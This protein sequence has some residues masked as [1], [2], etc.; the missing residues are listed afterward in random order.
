[1]SSIVVP[2]VTPA[3]KRIMIVTVAA[4]VVLQIILGRFL[5]LNQWKVLILHPYQV[6]ESFYVWQLFTYQFFHD[7]SPAHILFNM[8]MI[9][10]VG[11]ELESR[12]GAKFFT[13]YYLMSGAGAALI[14]C[15]GTAIYAALTGNKMVMLIP[16]LGASGSLFGLLLAYGIIFSERTIYFMGFFPLKAKHFV[17]LAGALDFASLISSGVAGGEVAYLAHLGGLASGFVILRLHVWYKNQNVKSKLKR[18][19]SNLRLVVDNEKSK[20]DDKPKYWN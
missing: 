2:P 7:L 20:E 12:W 3:V 10:F 17:I 6:V 18:K 11:S 13:F 16:V 4:W 15:L 8:L 1:M 14:Y 5:N 19:T 9:W